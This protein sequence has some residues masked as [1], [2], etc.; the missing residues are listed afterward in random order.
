LFTGIIEELGA[1]KA[2]GRGRDSAVLQVQASLV[3][4]DLKKGDSVSVNG[5][6]LTVID[7]TD[8]AFSAEVMAETLRKSNLGR[9]KTG[10]RVNLERALRP[11][12]RLGGHLVSGH[13]DGVGRI[14]SVS[15]EDIATVFAIEAPEDVLRYIVKK[16]SVAIDGISLTVV[17]F[18]KAGFRVSIIP[19]TA[20]LT[21]L[22]TKGAGDTVNLESDMIAKYVERLFPGGGK[23]EGKGGVDKGFLAE[24]GFM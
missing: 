21:T 11:T 19:H 5:V 18:D 9:L 1:V 7:F 8:K 10:D 12:D 17:D 20:S 23:G 14:K 4:A 16:G 22:G 15:K 3:T 13:I 2:V 24:H 6:C